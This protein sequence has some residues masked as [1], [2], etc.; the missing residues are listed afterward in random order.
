MTSL[1]LLFVGAV[2]LINGLVFLGVI[3]AKSSTAINLLV[4]LF[5]AGTVLFLVLPVRGTDEASLGI[6]L[7]ASG[8]LLF[9][10]TYLGVAFNNLAG[11]H[12]AALG[13]YC[14]W[15]ALISM[16]L[17]AINFSH[18]ADHRVGWLWASWSLLFLAFFLSLALK[19]EWMT[20]PAGAL[21][22]M[23]AFITCTVPAALQMT[24]LWT[25]VPVSAIAAAQIIMTAI[26]VWHVRSSRRTWTGQKLDL[27]L[28]SA[29]AQ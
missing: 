19:V 28:A 11:A 24:G 12:G 7:G 5:L 4:G 26:L 25:T 27:Q 23:Q 3:D 17:A 13:W 18:L 6:I 21:A 29:V 16:F 15:A 9:S 10:F 2:L 8:F 22:I 1:V 14:G 20:A